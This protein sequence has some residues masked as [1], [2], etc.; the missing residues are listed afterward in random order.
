MFDND[1]LKYSVLVF[2]CI[3]YVIITAYVDWLPLWSIPIAWIIISTVILD[4]MQD[5]E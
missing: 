3:I 4:V 2:S 5:Q 1:L